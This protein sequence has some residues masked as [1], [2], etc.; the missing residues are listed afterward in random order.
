MRTHRRYNGIYPSI[1]EHVWKTYTIIIKIPPD[2]RGK[3]RVSYGRPCS[4][5]RRSRGVQARLRHRQSAISEPRIRGRGGGAPLAA[6]LAGRLPRGG[7][8][9]PGQQ[10]GRASGRERGGQDVLTAG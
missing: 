8:P 7:D 2:A 5:T 3:R 4:G 9:A 6:S 10:I 1:A